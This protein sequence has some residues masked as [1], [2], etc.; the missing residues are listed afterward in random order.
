M[1]QVNDLQET[2]KPAKPELKKLVLRKETLRQL[3]PAELRL[4]PG[5]ARGSTPDSAETDCGPA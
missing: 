4:V 5:G 1:E 3:T 2:G